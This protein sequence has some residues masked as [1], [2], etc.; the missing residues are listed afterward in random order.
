[1][2]V[3]II[4]FGISSFLLW[5]ADKKSRKS[6]LYKIYICT[7]LLFPIC[8]AALRK[9][10]VGT[11]TAQYV[12]L[13]YNE[14]DKAN[15]FI[16]YYHSNVYLIYKYVPVSDWELGYL[17][18]VYI[19]TKIFNSFQGVLFA[20][21]GLIILFIYKGL[22]YF[23]DK[24]KI[25]FS[26]L[27]FYL[28]F[29]NHSLNVMRQWIAMSILFYGFTL[30]IDNK[31]VKYLF[32]V[33][34]ASLFHRSGVI[35][36]IVFALYQ[37]INVDKKRRV[38]FRINNQLK[39]ISIYKNILI[40][41]AGLTFVVGF[42]TFTKILL[43]FGNDMERYVK[44]YLNGNITFLP[45]QIIRRLP[46]ILLIV[47]NWKK[48]KRNTDLAPFY[49]SICI[50]DCMISQLNSIF[51]QSGRISYYF[52]EYNMLLFPELIQVQSNTNNRRIVKFILFMYLA[53][54]WYYEFVYRGWGE[55]VPYKFFFYK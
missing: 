47:T 33:F 10:G 38:K 41:I 25:W 18:L 49:V 44:V 15:D 45:N 1:M 28:M 53:I 16:A 20:T 29:Y 7:A 55:T 5:L 48:L 3:Y 13:L 26:M 42:N 2:I 21:H 17:I 14:A 35:G 27:V 31:K 40:L 34:A 30:L 52:S 6:V 51:N 32:L 19:A 43:T 12:W 4:V 36:I 24:I 50:I 37:Y 11:D 54:Y 8:L 23:K 39:D 9:M 22:V 46:I